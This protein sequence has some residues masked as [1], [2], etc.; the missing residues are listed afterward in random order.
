MPLPDPI[1]PDPI[2]ELQRIC[3]ARAGTG[4]SPTTMRSPRSAEM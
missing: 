2:D 1:D 3:L 4:F